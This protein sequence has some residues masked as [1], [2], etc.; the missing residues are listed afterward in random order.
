MRPVLRRRNGKKYRRQIRAGGN[1]YLSARGFEP[2]E[3]LGADPV[4]LQ[5]EGIQPADL[6]AAAEVI[7][8]KQEGRV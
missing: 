5:A 2:V 1:V 7:Q 3:Q 6:N 4:A 8:R